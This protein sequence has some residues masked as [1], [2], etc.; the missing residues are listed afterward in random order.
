MT[1]GAVNQVTNSGISGLRYDYNFDKNFAV[2]AEVAYY[3]NNVTTSAINLTYHD[4]VNSS[5]LLKVGR[6]DYQGQATNMALLQAR[7]N[8]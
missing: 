2:G 1:Y 5:V 4:D 3:T 7:V 6:Q 8:F